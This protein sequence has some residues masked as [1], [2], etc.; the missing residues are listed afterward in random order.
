MGVPFADEVRSGISV[1]AY[2]VEWPTEFELLAGQLGSTLGSRALGIDHVGS[3]S[4]PGLRSR[5]RS[6]AVRATFISGSVMVPMRGTH[7]CFGIICGPTTVRG[8]DGELSSSAWLPVFP[9]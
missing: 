6:V 3:T 5:H 2:R 7:C 1:V 4:V 8:R 9:I